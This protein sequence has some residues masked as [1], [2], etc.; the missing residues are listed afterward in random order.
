M[1]AK[2]G[3]IAFQDGPNRLGGKFHWSGQLSLVGL[4]NG[5]WETIQTIRYGF[6]AKSTQVLYFTPMQMNNNWDP[7]RDNFYQSTINHLN[8]FR[9]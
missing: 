1:K 4:K 2:F 9:R 5:K 7:D 6:S 3:G 8:L